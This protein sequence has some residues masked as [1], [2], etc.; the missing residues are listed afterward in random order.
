M[1]LSAILVG[2]CVIVVDRVL[3]AGFFF[4]SVFGVDGELALRLGEESPF[5]DLLVLTTIEVFGVTES[6]LLVFLYAIYIVRWSSYYGD[7]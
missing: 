2:D 1:V 7:F 5:A 6:G 4:L 3:C